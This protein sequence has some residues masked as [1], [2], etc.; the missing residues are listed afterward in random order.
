MSDR[1]RIKFLY[2]FLL[3]SGNMLVAQKV[4]VLLRDGAVTLGAS[5]HIAKQAIQQVLK[6]SFCVGHWIRFRFW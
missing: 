4:F 5:D 2:R 6:P 1:D 3:R